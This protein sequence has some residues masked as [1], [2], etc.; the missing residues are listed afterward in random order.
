MTFG[1]KKVAYTELYGTATRQLRGGPND[2]ENFNLVH[3]PSDAVAAK[4]YG[5]HADD[6]LVKGIKYEVV[7][8][9]S[10]NGNT[11]SDTTGAKIIKDETDFTGATLAKGDQF[12]V[13]SDADIVAITTANMTFKR[14]S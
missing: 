11:T 9:G 7:S 6:P 5:I 10:S 12:T 1:V 2:G 14:V 4:K 3:V 13:N 8:L